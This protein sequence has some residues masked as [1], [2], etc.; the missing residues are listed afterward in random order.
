MKK[1]LNYEL[2]ELYIFIDTIFQKPKKKKHLGLSGTL[3]TS[4]LADWTS[5][6]D[7]TNLSE[8]KHVAIN[9]W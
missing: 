6:L 2:H 4:Q 1:P 9:Y 7:W 8:D 5:N 3:W